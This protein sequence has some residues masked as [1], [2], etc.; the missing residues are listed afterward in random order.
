MKQLEPNLV[1]HMGDNVYGDCRDDEC[2][3]LRQAYPYDDWAA[4]PSFQGAKSMLPQVATL[5]D[6]DYGQGDCHA[7]NPYK[8]IAKQMFVD[9]F[10]IPDRN[11][12]DGVY[13][14]YEWGPIGQ[15]VH[16]I[17]RYSI[18]EISFPR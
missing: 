2:S 11:R 16:D 9:F 15:R 12:R 13:G 4:H 17:V 1:A 10:D 14:A 6:H 7:D 5:D 8:D 3:D 18:C